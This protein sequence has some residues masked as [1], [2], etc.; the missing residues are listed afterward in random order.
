MTMNAQTGGGTTFNLSGPVTLLPSGV[1]TFT[2]TGTFL[3]G[4]GSGTVSG[5][6]AQQPVNGSQVS[7][8][9]LPLLEGRWR[10]K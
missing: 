4:G 2:P 9:A 10:N 3:L 6:W 1:L 7:Q 5:T 8:A